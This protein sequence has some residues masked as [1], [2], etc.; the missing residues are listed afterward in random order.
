[1]YPQDGCPSAP[2]RSCSDCHGC[3]SLGVPSNCGL[4]C[5]SSLSRRAAARGDHGDSQVLEVSLGGALVVGV[6]VQVVQV[7]QGEVE[8]HG[9]VGK[10]RPREAR[11]VDM[12]VLR[13]G[14]LS[15]QS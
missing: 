6:W 12:R 3:L 11:Q 10:T 1:M 13:V 2:E 9:R 8:E 4:G 7:G 15:L 5:C 14:V